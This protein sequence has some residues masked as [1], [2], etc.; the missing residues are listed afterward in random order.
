VRSVR[1]AS[2]PFDHRTTFA[3]STLDCQTVSVGTLPTPP[4]DAARREEFRLRFGEGPDA[5]DRTRPIAPDAVFDDIVRLA[6]LHAGSTVVE[7]GP[8][9]GQATRP[10]AA[11]S[12]RVLAIEIDPRLAARASQNLAGLPNVAVR[13]K[14]FEAWQPEDALFDAVVAC[15]SFHWVD[16]DVRFVKAAAVLKPDGHLVL[17]ST[18]VVVPDG[19][20][21]FWSAVQDD[22][23]AVGAARVDP[24]TKHP[25]LVDD[26][27]SAVR[28]SGF[29]EEP[30]VTRH[31]FEVAYSAAEYATNLSTQSGVKELPHSAQ[32]ELLRLIRRRIERHGGRLTVHHLAVLTVARVRARVRR[33]AEGVPAHVHGSSQPPPTIRR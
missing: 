7:I 24:A 12:L 31:Q 8:G 14:S 25:D 9:T 19:A 26:L 17:V 3:P 16:P 29:F 6:G 27:G 28:A 23:S 1:D 22:W 32:A 18:P 11:R 10:L 20:S 13:E 21:R 15:N 33:H 2:Q 5:Y 4:S 30:T